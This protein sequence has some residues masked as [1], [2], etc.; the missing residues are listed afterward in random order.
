MKF[1]GMAKYYLRKYLFY[2]VLALC[3]AGLGLGIAF[4][5]LA[6]K[7]PSQ[8][9]EIVK[10][11]D[12]EKGDDEKDDPVSKTIIFCLPVENGSVSKDYCVDKLVYSST[13]TRYSTH[14]GIDFTGKSGASVLAVYDGKIESVET[15]LLDG[16]VIT[17][18]HGN[19]LKSV[20][21]SVLDG[22]SVTV[23]KTVKKGDKIGVISTSC[24]QEYKDGEHV[25]LE[26]CE[27]GKSV[28]PMK[29]I[30]TEEK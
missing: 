26:V 27:N 18:D 24:R 8:G 13:L 20:Y 22:E 5:C 9:A 7:K 25:H 23:G 30:L 17:I 14:S 15:G 29:Y 19:G 6:S 2:I 11:S 28:N 21:K 10:P 4:A 12:D 3:L 16:T 1:F